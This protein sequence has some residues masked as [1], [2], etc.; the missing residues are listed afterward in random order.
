MI[1][2]VCTL[3]EDE[4]LCNLL[5]IKHVLATIVLPIY[6]T[7]IGIRKDATYHT[8]TLKGESYQALCAWKC[9]RLFTYSE[10]DSQLYCTI[11]H[12]NDQLVMA[13]VHCLHTFLCTDFPTTPFSLIVI[14]GVCH[15]D[16]AVITDF[17][18]LIDKARCHSATIMSPY[19]LYKCAGTTP[20]LTCPPVKLSNLKCLELDACH[21]LDQEWLEILWCLTGSKLATLTVCGPPPYVS[22]FHFLDQ[23]PNIKSL[24]AHCCWVHSTINCNGTVILGALQKIGENKRATLPPPDNSEK[25]DT[26]TGDSD[27]SIQTQ[28]S[29]ILQRICHS[30]SG[31]SASLWWNEFKNWCQHSLSLVPLLPG[32]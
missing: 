18:C 20:A 22:L 6:A 15:L 12:E 27:T 24:E 17:I 14:N 26:H 7:R 28:S 3:A 2:N 23:H 25:S 5:L 16:P 21:F 31:G 30:Y 10:H 32:A 1:H 29:T 4:D 11:D 13:Q 19:N 8:I 9:S